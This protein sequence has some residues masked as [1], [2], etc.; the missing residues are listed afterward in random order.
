MVLFFCLAMVGCGSNE[1]ASPAL[2]AE[3]PPLRA[4]L[5]EPM[6]PD[7]GLVEDDGRTLWASPTDG[8]PIT[9]AG[10][11]NGSELIFHFRPVL[12]QATPEGRQVWQ[13]LRSLTQPLPQADHL[14]VTV[15]PGE[16][17]GIVE[18]TIVADPLSTEKLPLLRREIEQLLATS[19]ADRH[20]T[21]IVSPGFLLGDGGPLIGGA[22]APLRRL[23]QEYAR[24][25]WQAMALSFHLD[26][27]NLYWELRVIGSPNTP[28]LA[29]ARQLAKTIEA[30]SEELAVLVDEQPWSDYS[31]TFLQQTPAMLE[32]ASRY[33]RRGTE[34]RQAVV[35]GYLPAKAAHNV[36]LAAELLI[37]E[38]S[39]GTSSK[40]SQQGPKRMTLAEKLRQPVTIAFTREPMESALRILTNTLLGEHE[41]MFKIIGRDLQLEGITRN[42]MLSLDVQEKPAEEALVDLLRQANPDPLATGPADP[43]QKLVYVLRDEVLVITTRAAARRR[44][45]PLPAVFTD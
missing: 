19:D 27:E 12:L 32:V 17:Y 15:A 39:T 20:A 35:N 22:G 43:R 2:P 24:D 41:T 8:P 45:E 21:L 38:L 36:A 42:Q 10:I 3:A 5:P 9:L 25:D 30:T 11:A 31:R 4:S 37:A 14:L 33:T 16:S 29:R 7:D 23:L 6:A 26:N 34:G 18:T 44:R 40:P 13:T 28:E 1:S